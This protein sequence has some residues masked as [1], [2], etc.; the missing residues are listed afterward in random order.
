MPNHTSARVSPP[1]PAGQRREQHPS[2]AGPPPPVFL[3]AEVPLQI[4]AVTAR[5]GPALQLGII[6]RWRLQS[7]NRTIPIPGARRPPLGVRRSQNRPPIWASRQPL[8]SFNPG[9]LP[10]F[11]SPSLA[12]SSPPS[13]L[14]SKSESSVTGNV[15]TP[16]NQPLAIV[17]PRFHKRRR[18]TGA[19]ISLSEHTLQIC[20]SA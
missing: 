19:C 10:S 6:R 11:P 20:P 7:Q 1:L 17:M 2:S 9:C 5:A 13:P 3:H 14:V 8:A 12:S 16:R 4:P 15:G 18:Q